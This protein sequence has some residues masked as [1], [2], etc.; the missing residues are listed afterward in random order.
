[1]RNLG[2]VWERSRRNL[3]EVHEKGILDDIIISHVSQ[4]DAMFT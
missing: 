2:E 3:G 4:D 1:M